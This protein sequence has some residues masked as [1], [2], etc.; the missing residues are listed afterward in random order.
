MKIRNFADVKF[1]LFDNKTIRQKI[2]KNIFWL[3]VVEII[4]EGIGFIVVIW[5]ASKYLRNIAVIFYINRDK[6]L[7]YA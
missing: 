7:I 1:L 2:F 5:L 3:V 4:S 6:A